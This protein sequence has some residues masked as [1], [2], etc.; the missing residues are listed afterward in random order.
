MDE[1]YEAAIT[2]IRVITDYYDH[3]KSSAS[4]ASN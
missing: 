2:A 1:K 3:L 4:N